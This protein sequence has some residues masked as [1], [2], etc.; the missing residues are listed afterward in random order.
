MLPGQQACL[1]VLMSCLVNLSMPGPSSL[2]MAPGV[3][4]G[5]NT[6]H[7]VANCGAWAAVWGGGAQCAPHGLWF[8]PTGLV[9]GGWVAMGAHTVL[10][11]PLH[12]IVESATKCHFAHFPPHGPTAQGAIVGTC[13]ACQWAK[14]CPRG[15]HW[16]A[17]CHVCQGAAHSHQLQ[18]SRPHNRARR[19]SPHR[20]TRC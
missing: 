4:G 11:Q 9:D 15:V 2:S 5:W 8:A 10:Q 13:K 1:G 6:I 3:H 17:G 7:I 14:Q 19:C 16:Q 12:C 18:R 20:A